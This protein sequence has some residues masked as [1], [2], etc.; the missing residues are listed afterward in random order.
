[1]ED[2]NPDKRPDM[3]TL[4][5]VHSA[6]GLEF[7]HV[8]VVHLADDLFPHKRSL[9]EG[10]EEEERRLFYVAVTRAQHSLVF[11]MAK[12]R[13]RYGELIKQRPSRFL[14]DLD[15]ELFEGPAPGSAAGEARAKREVK[16]A[17][18]KERFFQQMREMRASGGE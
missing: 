5:T 1:P 15:P 13:K 11:S 16:A 9:S 17:Q 12:E 3:V 6:K 10:G 18:A 4:L 7:P 14:L 8:Y 2:E